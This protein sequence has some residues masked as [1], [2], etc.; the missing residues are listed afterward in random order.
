MDKNIQVLEVYDFEELKRELSNGAN[1]TLTRIEEK[2]LE[3]QFL[4]LLN[5]IL[6]ADIDAGSPMTIEQLDDFIDYDVDYI[7][8]QLN[9]NLWED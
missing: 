5:E 3:E 4:E 1:Q 6:T 9:V 7:G 8:T 2:G